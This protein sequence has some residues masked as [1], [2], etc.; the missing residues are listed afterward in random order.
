MDLT[1]SHSFLG[2]VHLDWAPELVGFSAL[3]DSASFVRVIDFFSG[4]KG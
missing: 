2:L 4:A 1:D 3:D